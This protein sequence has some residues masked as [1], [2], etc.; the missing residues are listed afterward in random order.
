MVRVGAG[1]V[2][3]ESEEFV[4][5]ALSSLWSL[6]ESLGVSSHHYRGRWGR[7]KPRL[8][9]RAFTDPF[10]SLAGAERPLQR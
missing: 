1:W 6:P 8:L 5:G 2:R 9:L 4:Y 10:P 7:A 3:D